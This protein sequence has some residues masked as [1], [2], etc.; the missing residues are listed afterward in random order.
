MVEASEESPLEERKE[1]GLTARPRHMDLK[2]IVVVV[3]LCVTFWESSLSFHLEY[4]GMQVCRAGTFPGWSTLLTSGWTSAC[5]GA[6][7][8]DSLNV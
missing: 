6:Y 8:G 2:K 3:C 7:T 4:K 1:A 5:T